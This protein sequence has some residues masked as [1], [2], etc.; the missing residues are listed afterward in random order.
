M[1]S[2]IVISV[3]FSPILEE[4]GPPPIMMIYISSEPDFHRDS[5]Y[6]VRNLKFHLWHSKVSEAGWMFPKTLSDVSNRLFWCFWHGGMFSISLSKVYKADWM[7]PTGLSDAS[8][9]GMYSISFS[10]VFD[11]DRMFSIW[12]ILHSDIDSGMGSPDVSCV[13]ILISELA[14]LM[15][16]VS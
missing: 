14:H 1:T 15:Y 5:E 3:C 12:Y 16:P 10:D 6:E 7:F 2:Y 8:N 11:T 4:I 9:P 13:L